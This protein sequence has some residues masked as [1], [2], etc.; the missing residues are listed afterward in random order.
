[1]QCF[2][3]S[4]GFRKHCVEWYRELVGAACIAP[5]RFFGWTSRSGRFGFFATAASAPLFLFLLLL[6]III[7]IFF[8]VE[9]FFFLFLFLFSRS[10]IHIG[11]VA[12]IDVLQV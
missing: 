8:F 6:F 9:E 11:Y 12:I 10:Q 7:I 2:L 1:M 3:K 5:G 4:Y